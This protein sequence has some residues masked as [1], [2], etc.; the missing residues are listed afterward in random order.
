[1]AEEGTPHRLLRERIREL[2]PETPVVATVL[3]PRPLEPV[4]GR[5]VAFFGT[6]PA[7]AHARIAA[8]LEREHGARV[9]AVS[10]SLADRR[11][12]REELERLEAEVVLVELKAAAIDVVA[13]AA[14][15]RGIEVVLAAN[16][17]VTL[18]GEP[19]L[20]AHLERLA[21]EACA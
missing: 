8:H 20:D 10:G 4:Q 13:E 1:M 16:D 5:A 12:L 9:V 11:A 3:R 18:D 7:S 2:V 17:V 6:A 19:D 21:A 15:A 14:A